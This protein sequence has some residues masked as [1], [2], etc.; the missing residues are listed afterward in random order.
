MLDKVLDRSARVPV[1][2]GKFTNLFLEEGIPAEEVP[3]LTKILAAEA[4][5]DLNVTLLD[6]SHL[7]LSVEQVLHLARKSSILFYPSFSVLLHNDSSQANLHILSHRNVVLAWIQ[8]LIA[9]GGAFSVVGTRVSTQTSV[10]HEYLAMVI[11]YLA[12]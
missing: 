9:L 4:K 3:L 2:R 1:V 6:I 7:Q 12:L 11:A 8:I 5:F 10:P